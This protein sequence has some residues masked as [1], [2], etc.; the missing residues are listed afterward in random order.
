[1]LFVAS[2]LLGMAFASAGLI[3]KEI[4]SS[5]GAQ[6][7]NL[8]VHTYLTRLGVLSNLILPLLALGAAF[9][10]RGVEGGGLAV[11]GLVAGAIFLGVLRLPYPFRLIIAVAGVPLMGIIFLVLL[12]L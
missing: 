9:A 12:A 1:M 7:A 3:A 6:I 10:V 2:F 11:L 4:N 8:R 5:I